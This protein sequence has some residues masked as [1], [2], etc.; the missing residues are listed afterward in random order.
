MQEHMDRQQ[1]TIIESV[2]S[3]SDFCTNFMI[4][5]KFPQSASTFEFEHAYAPRFSTR[6]YAFGISSSELWNKLPDHIKNA[7]TVVSLSHL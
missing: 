1:R 7:K 3:L 5:F 6:C 2:V 4:I